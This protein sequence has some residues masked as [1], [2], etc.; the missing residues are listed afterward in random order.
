MSSI[1]I[2]VMTGMILGIG[3]LTA[4][5]STT[6]MEVITKKAKNDSE[7]IGLTIT[8]VGLAVLP[9]FLV[10]LFFGAGIINPLLPTGV[11]K[12]ATFIGVMYCYTIP[13]FYIFKMLTTIIS[14]TISS[15]I[16][17]KMGDN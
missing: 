1:Q 5:G 7:F 17:K 6:A 9:A 3:F 12:I 13:A 4:L 11:A 2:I 8:N 16:I 15:K 10:S 14:N